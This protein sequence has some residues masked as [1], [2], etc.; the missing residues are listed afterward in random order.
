MGYYVQGYGNVKAKDKR[1]FDSIVK[2]LNKS[3][4]DPFEYDIYEDILEIDLFEEG[5]YHEEDIHELLD[6]ITSLIAEGN[7]EYTGEDARYCAQFSTYAVVT[8]DGK[9]HGKGEMGWFACS[10]E[11]A[12]EAKDWEEHYKERFIDT[13]DPE[14]YLTIVDCHI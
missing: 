5:N 8:P 11:T 7:I 2:V 1:S 14:W 6:S 13:A 4:N 10:S 9:W 12:D 3:N